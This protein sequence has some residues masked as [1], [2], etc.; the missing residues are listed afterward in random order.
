MNVINKLILLRD[1]MKSHA[2]DA[3]ILTGTD[4][5]LSEYTTPEW[6]DILWIS[7]FTGSYC[8][9]V[10]TMNKALLWT[11]SRYFI[12]AESQL[13]GSGIIMI[14]DKQPNTISIENWLLTELNAG[15]IVAI[16]G[17]TI[18]SSYHT[19][20]KEKLSAK[21]ITLCLNI[22]MV[23]SIWE[24]RPITSQTKIIDYPIRFSGKSRTEKV[25]EIRNRLLNLKAEATLI[26]QLDDLAWTFN[27][28]GN[29]IE[30]NPLF[31]GYGYVDTKQAILFVK[32]GR[33]T[34]ELTSILL[35]D[36]I[37]VEP[38]DSLFSVLAKCNP[39]IIY[40]DPDRTNSIIH[41]FL[42][43]KSTVIQGIAIPTR[44]KS[45]KNS[46]EIAGIKAAH[47]RDGIAMVN[48]FQWF[49]EDKSIKSELCIADK[50]K[51]FRSAQRFYKGESFCSIVGFG[52]H[53]AI[54]HYS[55]SKETNAIIE[56]NGILLIDSGGQYLDGTTDITRTIGVG[57]ITTRQ[58]KD[59]TLIL[60]GMINLTNMVFP[61]G[62][63]GHSLDV[64]ARKYLW[65]NNL[66]Y[67]HGTGHGIGHFLSVHEGPMS[68]RSESTNESILEGQIL[69]NEPGIYRE[70]EYGIRIENVVFCKKKGISSYGT[71]NSFQTL[72][73]CPIDKKMIISSLL[74]DNE[75]L[76]I[77]NYHQKIFKTLK[78]YL[79]PTV[80][81][82]LSKS[83]S[84]I[85]T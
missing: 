78:P 26:S 76:W 2:V 70:G 64:I 81:K 16:D 73:L 67:N 53:G 31:T 45:I 44:L 22:T 49:E 54:V 50:L 24:N 17:Y 56:S 3:V 39:A 30:Y 12:Q 33:V 19:K 51:E 43:E 69:S 60:K 66:N 80:I 35:N 8:K 14:K 42:A 38:Y 61:E 55:A 77:N 57:K 85:K 74:N 23:H 1:Q 48:F 27:L 84:P 9:M 65:K 25:L 46:T 59:F 5:H 62:T 79:K 18:P 37:Q 13:Q 32:Q 47:R 29:E 15:S 6:K 4:P 83:C 71:F 72:T 20:L 63:K 11:D 28:R 41:N 68:I 75:V 34:P 40:L 82:W 7:G 52:S 36:G 10:I 21:G 58:K